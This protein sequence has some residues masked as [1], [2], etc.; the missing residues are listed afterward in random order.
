MELFLGEQ[1]SHAQMHH[2]P[3]RSAVAVIAAALYSGIGA[4]SAGGAAPAGTPPRLGAPDFR[5]SAERPVG[6]RGD[7]SGHFPGA[8][9]PLNWSY[10]DGKGTNIVWQVRLP[11]DSPSSVIVVG[12]KLFTTGN[13]FELICVDKHTGRILWVR[14]VSPYDAATAEERQAN[15]DVFDKLDKLAQERDELLA[16]V[17][18]TAA[19]SN[20][21]ANLGAQ[22]A[23]TDAEMMK[24]L[25]GTDRV[26]YKNAGLG[27]GGGDEGGF[28]ATTPASDGTLVY[29]WNGWGVT[30]CFDLDGNRKWTRFDKLTWQEHGHYS[31]PL[32]AG[33]LVI[34]YIGR[35]YLAVDKK[36]G[37]E[38]WR[39]DYKAG[40]GE[41]GWWFA[42]PVGTVIG[43][44]NVFV[45]GDG[46]LIRAADGNRFAKGTLWHTGIGSPVIGGGFAVWMEGLGNSPVR[47]CQLPEKADAPFKP[48]VKGATMEPPEPA[49]H[50]VPSPLYH[51]GLIYVCGNNSSITRGGGKPGLEKAM[52]L[53]V[54]DVATE[55][56]VYSKELDFGEEPTREE[57]KR[58]DRPYGSGM[59]ASPALAGGR[60][61][62]IGNFGTTLIIEPGRE[63]KEVSRNIIDQRISHYY[64]DD[65][66]E[67]TVSNPFFDGN[68]IFYRAQRYLYCI[69]EPGNQE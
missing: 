20:A 7:G 9:P 47:Y 39:T 61:F 13:N 44:E 25:A 36:T 35:Q 59:A 8:T 19:V 26:K 62:L 5:P 21:M 51:D 45:T 2:A 23:K 63:Y 11:F 24:L 17:P 48:V 4:A 6:W 54:C 14:P 3:M 64:R 53:F 60:I 42:S 27:G 29:A 40:P 34:T 65:R 16:K 22:I 50:V 46:S 15:R 67:G 69:G 58:N 52:V 1:R 32:L 41:A 10:R 66:I 43:G 37:K 55:K 30:A 56:I 57:L 68:R 12:D 28:M 49:R 38:A 31:S 18:T 33:D